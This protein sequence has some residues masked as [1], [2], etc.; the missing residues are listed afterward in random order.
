MHEGLNALTRTEFLQML[1]ALGSVNTAGTFDSRG[2]VVGFKT[3]RGEG[4]T[5]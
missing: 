3:L 1:A 5:G 2:F 4:T